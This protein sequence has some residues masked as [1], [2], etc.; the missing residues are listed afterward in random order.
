MKEY[1]EEIVRLVDIEL[2]YFSID[3]CDIS[4]DVSFKLVE[5][6]HG[7]LN[8]L[9]DKF[10]GYKFTSQEEEICFFKEMKPLILSR[11]LYFNKI[12]TIELKR[13]N[14]SNIL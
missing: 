2:E 10:I 3:T 14:G 9:R 5:F 13:P 8:E 1:F 7:K 6:L 4:T 12:Y 11:L